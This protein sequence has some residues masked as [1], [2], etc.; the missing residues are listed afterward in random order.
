MKKLF[1]EF[2]A[3]IS[4][5]NILDMAVG[6]IIGSAFTAIVTALTDGILKPLINGVIFLINGGS[7]SEE[8]YTFLHKAYS[9]GTLDL[10]NSIYI[11]WGAFISAI[12][13]FLLIAI[14]IFAI[15]KIINKVRETLDYNEVMKTAIQ[16][17]LDSDEELNELE[18]KWMKR[19]QKKNPSI[20]PQKT[21]AVEPAPPAEPEVSSTDKLL[22]QILEQLKQNEAK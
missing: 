7:E 10:S 1:N 9:D 13:N 22:A 11:D 4:R 17:K 5:G 21:V 20:V 12:I 14:T 2:K 18:K 8:I 19:M 16:R 6:V 15:I 3:F